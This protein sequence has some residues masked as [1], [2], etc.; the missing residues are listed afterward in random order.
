[1]VFRY[2]PHQQVRNTLG[3]ISIAKEYI[4][5]DGWIQMTDGGQTNQSASFENMAIQLTR[6][7]SYQMYFDNQICL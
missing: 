1:M 4:Y 2:A 5:N 3:C 7:Y 6:K